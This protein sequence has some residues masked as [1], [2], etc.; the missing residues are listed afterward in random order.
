MGV[1]VLLE[2]FAT[3]ICC[4]VYG[5]FTKIRWAVWNGSY[6]VAL[7]SFPFIRLKA[8]IHMI[9][10]CRRS[11]RLAGGF[12]VCAMP[13]T[14]FH[15]RLQ[16]WWRRPMLERL[17]YGDAHCKTF[18]SLAHTFDVFI[19]YS[20]WC[21]WWWLCVHR[22]CTDGCIF[23]FLEKAMEKNTQV[24]FFFDKHA[25]WRWHASNHSFIRP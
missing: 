13:N 4:A 12:G 2:R 1:G 16:V 8:H 22:V 7:E 17:W 20:S 24:F 10:V 11:R 19:L 23:S 6:R 18:W 25:V 3:A 14:N 15:A 5:R 21:R 9:H